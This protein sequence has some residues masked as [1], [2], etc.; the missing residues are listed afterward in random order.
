M[1]TK[2]ESYFNWFL[3]VW[4]FGS[5]YA[6]V[7]QLAFQKLGADGT[8]WGYTPGWQREI[9]FWNLGLVLIIIQSL[10][11]GT[12]N[13]KV[14]ITRALVVLSLLFG[15]NHFLEIFKGGTIYS[16]IGGAVENYIAV[17]WGGILLMLNMRKGQE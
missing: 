6:A 14:Q 13:S 2:T 15:T 16:H 1:K 10:F 11:K 4:A 7:A 5:I 17:I 12:Y 8:H 3:R 9:G